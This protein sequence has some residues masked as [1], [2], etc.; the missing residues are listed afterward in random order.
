MS[1]VIDDLLS[2]PEAARDQASRGLETV[3]A[4]HTCDH[5]AQQLTQIFEELLS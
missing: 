2:D 1:S 3:L 5:R 4:R